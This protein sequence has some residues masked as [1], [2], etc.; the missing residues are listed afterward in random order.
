M[1][2]RHLLELGRTVH[3]CQLVVLAH[4][5]IVQQAAQFVF[6]HRFENVNLVLQRKG[7]RKRAKL[8]KIP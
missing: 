7:K 3:V 8:T 2:Q 6:G 1:I 5:V 4:I